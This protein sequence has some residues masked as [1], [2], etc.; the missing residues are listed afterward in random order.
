MRKLAVL[1][2]VSLDGVMQAPGGSEEDKSGGFSLGG[3]TFPYFDDDLGEAMGR[4]LS[5]PFDML[6]GRR[7]YDLFAAYWPESQEPGAEAL[8][9]GTKYVVSHDDNLKL[10]WDNS[11][12]ISGDIPS[13]IKELKG[14][15]GP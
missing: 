3:W 10:S 13:K 2:F 5:Q 11:V 8:N 4:Q 14:Q 7:T 12:L 1:T 6:L 9:K 15:D